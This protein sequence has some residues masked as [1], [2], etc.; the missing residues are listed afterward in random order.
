MENIYFKNQKELI[1]DLK[2]LIATLELSHSRASCHEDYY[3][4]L[5]QNM[6]DGYFFSMMARNYLLSLRWLLDL[7]KGIESKEV[8]W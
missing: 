6:K 7:K 2:F 8:I 3:G 5:A 4:I 1:K